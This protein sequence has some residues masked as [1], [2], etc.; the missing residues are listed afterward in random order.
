MLHVK[1]K[2]T[3][4]ERIV[5]ALATLFGFWFMYLGVMRNSVG[6]FVVGMLVTV[7]DIV[8]FMVLRYKR[9]EDDDAAR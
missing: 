9:S 4:E 6:L 2:L 3:T 5:T 1:R 7:S 8:I